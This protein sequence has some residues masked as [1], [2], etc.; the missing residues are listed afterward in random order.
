[1]FS[2]FLSFLL[3]LSATLVGNSF[4]QR[5]ENRS[6]Y[7][8]GFIEA[9]TKMKA[10]VAFGSYDIKTV[11]NESFSNIS[12]LE[13]FCDTGNL[14]ES[15]TDWWQSKVS[16]ID[17]SKG[18]LQEDT[19]LLIRFGEGLGITDTEG[20]ITHLDLYSD[21]ISQKLKSSKENAN[22]KGRLYRILGFSL[23]CAVTLV[24]L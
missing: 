5:L 22:V 7:L 8:G 14:E 21:L 16:S 1:M 9:L 10:L 4:S 2:L 11:V 6:K 15:F 19:E 17:K 12:G 20:Q 23:G 3:I 13:V 18:L 24:I